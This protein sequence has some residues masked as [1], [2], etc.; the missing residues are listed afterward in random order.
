MPVPDKYKAFIGASTPPASRSWGLLS[1]ASIAITNAIDGDLVIS[2]GD[3]AGVARP[4]VICVSMTA[5]LAFPRT[6]KATELE[7]KD[8]DAY[9]SRIQMVFHRKV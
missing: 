5:G 3:P 4:P 9:D 8:V 1:V 6:L 2:M 7:M